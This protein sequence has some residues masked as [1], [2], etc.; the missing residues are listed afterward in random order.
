M[1]FRYSSLI[2]F[3]TDVVLLAYAGVSANSLHTPME[4][5]S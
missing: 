2:S 4:L 1:R 5:M 3:K